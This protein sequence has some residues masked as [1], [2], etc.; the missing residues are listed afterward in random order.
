LRSKASSAATIE[1]IDSTSTDRTGRATVAFHSSAHQQ[2]SSFVPQCV[3]NRFSAACAQPQQRT[4]V[5][6][7]ELL[8]RAVHQRGR[9]QVTMGLCVQSTLN[10]QHATC[11]MKDATCNVQHLMCNLHRIL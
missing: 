4:D 10:L 1:P 6:F 8:R 3:L 2:P 9:A 7:N 5:H 11:G